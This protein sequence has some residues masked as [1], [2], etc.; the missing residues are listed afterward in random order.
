MRR[1]VSILVLAFGLKL[2]AAPAAWE[3]YNQARKAEKAGHVAEAYLLYAEAAAMEPKNRGYWLKSQ[4]LESRAIQESKEAAAKLKAAMPLQALA[5]A[6]ADAAE[7]DEA[8]D[9][10]SI[11][12]PS[13]QDLRDARKPLPPTTLE[14]GTLIQDFDILGDSKKLFEDVGRAY[15]LTAIFDADFQPSTPFR[16]HITEADY[17]TALRA[18]EATTG[19]FVVPVTGKQ[20]LVVKDTPQKRSEREPYIATQIYL[21]DVTSPQELAAA[22]TA[23]Q[24]TF[25]VDKVAFETADNTVILR[26]PISK[27]L[28]ARAMFEQ[29]LHPRA[30]R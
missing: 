16:F 27:I 25:N 9:T 18:L 24:Q 13:L 5:A 15:G 10:H 11:P 6:D 30:R 1:S 4:G 8:P 23:V 3:L 2:S 20:F 12:K 17:R 19:S 29:L 22:I 26:G 7:P 14:G 28:P 21:T